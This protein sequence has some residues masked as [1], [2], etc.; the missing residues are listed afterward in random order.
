V[1]DF[2]GI[3]TE[4]D[5]DARRQGGHVGAAQANDLESHGKRVLANGYL[6]RLPWLLALVVGAERSEISNSRTFF[7][8]KAEFESFE[9]RPKTAL[10]GLPD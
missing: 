1:I 9:S 10:S 6:L 3:R 7:L 4:R 8:R 2:P 5:K